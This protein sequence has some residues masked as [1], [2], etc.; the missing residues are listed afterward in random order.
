[1]NKKSIKGMSQEEAILRKS[2]EKTD[3]ER[4]QREEVA[5]VVSK[6]YPEEGEFDWS[7]AKLAMPPR[8]TAISMR[9]DNDVLD[10]FRSQGPGYQTRINAVLRSYMN[11]RQA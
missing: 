4:F 11:A 9:I 5:G 3:W 6:K 10:F 1:M 8:K 7:R 2:E